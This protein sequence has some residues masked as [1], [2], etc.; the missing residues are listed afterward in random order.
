MKKYIII[1]LFIISILI[2]FGIGFSVRPM[3]ADIN[4]DGKVDKLDFSILMANWTK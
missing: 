1:T 3:S 4:R 2:A